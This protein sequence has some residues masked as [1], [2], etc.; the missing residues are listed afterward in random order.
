MVD[1]ALY[2]ARI[3]GFAPVLQFRILV[4]KA[5]IARER[6]H[7]LRMRGAAAVF[8]VTTLLLMLLIGGVEP[9]PG[10]GQGEGA[11]ADGGKTA[12]IRHMMQTRSNSGTTGSNS[13]SGGGSKSGS[14]PSHTHPQPTLL[15]VMNKLTSMDNSMSTLVNDVADIKGHFSAMQEEVNELRREVED[16]KRENQELKDHR[17]ALWKSVDGLERKTD[18]LECRSKRNNLIFY[19]LEKR[20]NET[21]ANCEER[22]NELFT[23]TLELSE[24]VPFDRVH[25]LGDKPNAPLIAR[26]TYYKDKAKI[27]KAKNKLKGSNIFIGED[28]SERMRTVRKK[29]TMIMKEKRSEGKQVSLVYDHLIIDGKKYILKED[30]MGVREVMGK[31]T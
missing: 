25:R 31:R 26:C 7:G 2:R 16:L 6:I 19:G 24:S 30:G 10:P 21:T 27:L 8:A 28:F 18:D 17:E 9:N 5:K 22:L 1:V 23:D 20:D 11:A 15:D 4:R 14:V 12:D 29:L 3:G 13:N